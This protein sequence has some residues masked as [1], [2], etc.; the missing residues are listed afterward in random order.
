MKLYWLLALLLCTYL[1]PTAAQEKSPVKFGKISPADFAT[2]VYPIDSNANAVVIADIGNSEIVGNTKGFFSIKHKHFKR[3]HILNKNGYDAANVSVYLYSISND[4]EEELQSL[5]AYTYNLENGKVEETKLDTKEGVFKDKIDKNRV[6]KKFT[7]PNIKEGSI[8]EYEYTTVSDFLFNLQPWEF[9]GGYPRLW[10]EYN[11]SIPQ[12][13]NYVFLMQG[14]YSPHIKDAK[15]RR[16]AFNLSENGGAGASE[17]Y[18]FTAEVTDHRWVLKNLPALKEESYT[19]TLDNHLSKIEF[20]LSEYREPLTYKN[21]MG[22]WPQ[23]T[24]ELL[25]SEDFGLPLSKDNNWLGDEIDGLIKS[26]KDNLEKAHKIYAHVRDHYTSIGYRGMGMD[27]NLRNIVKSKKGS[28]V[29]INLLLTAMLRYANLPAYPVMLSTRSHGYTYAM[30]PILNRFNHVVVKTEAN[31]QDFYLD[32]TEGRLGFGKLEPECYNGHARIINPEAT[33]IELV[34]DSLKENKF[35]SVFLV[36]KEGGGQ[37]GSVQQTPGFI[38][39]YQLRNRIKAKGGADLEEEIKKQF[40]D[41][42]TVSEFMVDSLD[43]YDEV[44][45]IKYKIESPKPDEDILYF[46]PMFTE[47]IKENPFKS[48]ERFYPVEMPH[49]LNEV[50][51]LRLDVPVGYMVD[52]LPKQIVVKLNEEGDGFFEFRLSESGGTISL[53]SRVVINRAYF[54]PDEYEML[55]E[56]FNLIVKKHSEQIVFKKKK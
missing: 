35:T 29:E 41:N 14:Y 28:T 1:T 39:S 48:A 17:R 15:V 54:L 18:S 21:V 36:N 19:S 8:I 11:V 23:L 42:A 33:A 3:V 12:F 34:A 31:G 2:K 44:V 47:G 49:T 4:R 16:E 45:G 26:A 5:K 37:I 24:K 22:T 56:F 9:Q 38:E 30:Y 52:E 7:F 13:I 20:Q 6:I 51:T 10:T 53:R 46:N 25:T 55:R 43:K 50:Y 32:A 27:Q 40:A